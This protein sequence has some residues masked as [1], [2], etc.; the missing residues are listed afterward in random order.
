MK[1]KIN[2]AWSTDKSF[3]DILTT[4]IENNSDFKYSS[5]IKGAIKMTEFLGD[6]NQI[7]LLALFKNKLVEILNEFLS[8][9]DI[10]VVVKSAEPELV[11]RCVLSIIADIESINYAEL[12]N[13]FTPLLIEAA[14]ERSNNSVF[15]SICD[16][17][18]NDTVT[19]FKALLNSVPDEKKERILKIIIDAYQTPL[20][21]KL[22]ELLKSKSILVDVSEINYFY[23]T[24]TK[25]S[26]F[27]LN[28]N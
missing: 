24:K 13:K 16:I 15:V 7:K 17:L 3:S 20:C 27:S 14:K 23:S 4:A 22:S 12:S 28:I 18:N 21:V 25:N 1:I 26:N 8:N 9:N 6:D 5:I 10:S 11:N 2:L 19:M